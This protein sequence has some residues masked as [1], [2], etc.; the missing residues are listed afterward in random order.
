LEA[1]KTLLSN[2]RPYPKSERIFII[3]KAALVP[4]ILPNLEVPAPADFKPELPENALLRTE[5]NVTHKSSRIP[6]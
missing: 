4:S 5:G 2:A 6:V 3:P 1:L